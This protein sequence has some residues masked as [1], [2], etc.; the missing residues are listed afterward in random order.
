MRLRKRWNQLN[1]NH[2]DVSS[3]QFFIVSHSNPRSSQM[4]IFLR[5]L[6]VGHSEWRCSAQRGKVS[7]SYNIALLSFWLSKKGVIS[8]RFRLFFFEWVKDRHDNS[9]KIGCREGAY[10]KKRRTRDE[11]WTKLKFGERISD[12][13]VILNRFHWNVSR[14]WMWNVPMEGR[15]GLFVSFFLVRT[16]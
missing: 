9:D 2:L 15:N 13:G 10:C 6:V 4:F 14:S 8:G 12:V 3:T 7:H 16:R 11:D 1:Y 5:R